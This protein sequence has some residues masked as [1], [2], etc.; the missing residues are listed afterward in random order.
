M[1][2]APVQHE[3]LRCRRGT[4]KDSSA[5]GLG[6]PGSAQQHF[7][8]HRIRD[9]R[10]RAPILIV[11][12]AMPTKFEVNGK[13]VE[14]EVEPRLTLADCL[15]HKLRLT[16]THVGC[17]HGVCAACPVIVH[18]AGVRPCLMLAVQAEGAEVVTGGGASND[19]DPQAVQTPFSWRPV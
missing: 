2:P 15:R 1:Y 9:T 6:S 7:A 8:L 17:E 14:V 11:S 5:C 13:Q 10:H 4:A 3:V 16:G 18:G 19:A 12:R